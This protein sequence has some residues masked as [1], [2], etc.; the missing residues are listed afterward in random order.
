MKNPESFVGQKWAEAETT[1]DKLD[2][3]KLIDRVPF[4]VKYI[5]T[6][7]DKD[8][9]VCATCSN[10]WDVKS[11]VKILAN[12]VNNKRLLEAFISEKLTLVR[13][14]E[15]GQHR[16][17]Y[18]PVDE[19]LGDELFLGRRWKDAEQNPSGIDQAELKQNLPF[20]VKYTHLNHE[21]MFQTV[22]IK[23]S[24]EENI[25]ALIRT[26]KDLVA[27]RKLASVHYQGNALACHIK[28]DRNESAKNKDMAKRVEAFWR[29]ARDA[30][31]AFDGL[32][33]E[34][35]SP[36]ARAISL[37]KNAAVLPSYN[38]FMAANAPPSFEE[39]QQTRNAISG[40]PPEEEITLA[41]SSRLMK[42][43]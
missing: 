25:Q 40:A 4:N 19:S 24:T 42:R 41:R 35:R 43:Q 23:C 36:T 14:P 5:I 16:R 30:F 7:E 8:E 27:N 34:L 39:Y 38:D 15:V 32:E 21:D 31:R 3:E 13:G 26:L 10:K 6:Q 22:C 17:K 20:R 33:E 29:D 1:P 12:H 37:D 9:V 11:L 28:E 18:P 2:V